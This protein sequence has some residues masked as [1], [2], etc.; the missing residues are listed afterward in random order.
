VNSHG[1]LT[2]D[3]VV[4]QTRTCRLDDGAEAFVDYIL[5]NRSP[6]GQPALVRL[7]ALPTRGKFELLLLRPFD[8][9][10]LND[11]FLAVVNDTTGT[12]EITDKGTVEEYRRPSVRLESYRGRLTGDGTN[13][14]APVECELEFWDFVRPMTDDKGQPTTSYMFVELDRAAERFDLWQGTPVGA[15]RVFVS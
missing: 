5:A 2:C 8:S 14:T 15:P 6:A 11:D 13:P 3:F 9:F 12:L 10:P 4:S 7:R 1:L